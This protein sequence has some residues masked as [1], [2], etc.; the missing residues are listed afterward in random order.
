MVWYGPGPYTPCPDPLTQDEK[1][2]ISASLCQFNSSDI[3][4]VVEDMRGEPWT[5]TEEHGFDLYAERLEAITWEI[6]E[7]L[8]LKCPRPQYDRFNSNRVRLLKVLA[9]RVSGIRDAIEAKG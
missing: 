4:A 2:E 1:L 8:G 6:A 7:R 3:R 9:D 5:Q